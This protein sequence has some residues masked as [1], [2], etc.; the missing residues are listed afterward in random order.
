MSVSDARHRSEALRGLLLAVSEA[1]D[2][3]KIR[4]ILSGRKDEAWPDSGLALLDADG[5]DR[6]SKWI[7]E[8]DQGAPDTYGG[9]FSEAIREASMVKNQAGEPPSAI[10]VVCQ[11]TEL[12]KFDPVGLAGEIPIHTF[13]IPR[14]GSS[15]WSDQKTQVEKMRALADKSGG[16]FTVVSDDWIWLYLKSQP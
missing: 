12:E 2:G 9:D 5:K 11:K 3:V 1:G 13:G 7:K 4:C 15:G 8:R 10:L 6:F 16:K 14:L